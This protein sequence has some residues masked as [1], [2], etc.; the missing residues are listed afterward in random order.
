MKD[1]DAAELLKGRLVEKLVGK[2]VI[3]R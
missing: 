1:A 2:G 3:G